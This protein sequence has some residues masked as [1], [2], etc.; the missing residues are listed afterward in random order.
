MRSV[1]TFTLSFFSS[2]NKDSQRD[3]T[4]G[5]S[6]E[7]LDRSGLWRGSRRS[8][9]LFGDE[10]EMSLVWVPVNINRIQSSHLVYT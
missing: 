9:W 6:P 7:F 1:S 4:T 2:E 10:F 8:A 5:D 3:L